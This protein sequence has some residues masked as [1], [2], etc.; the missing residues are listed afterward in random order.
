MANPVFLDRSEAHRRIVELGR[1]FGFEIDPDAKVGSLSVGWQ[2]RVEI[3][4]ALYRNARILVLDEPTAVLTPQETEEI[5]AVLRRLAAEG[6]RIVFISHKLYEVLEIADRITVIRRGRVVGQRDPRRDER[7]GPRRADGRPRGPADGR[8]RRV[9]PGRAGPARRGPPRRRTTAATRWS[10][11]STSR[12]GP[13][14]SSASP[15]SPATARTSSSRRSSGCA[16]RRR[17]RVTLA[18]TDVTGHSPRAMNEAGVALRARGPSPVRPD[19]V[20]LARRQPG[21]HELLPGALRARDP[22]R[23]RARSSATPTRASRAVRHPDAVGDRHG[24]RRCPAATSRRWSSP[25]SSTATSSCSSSTSRRAA[26]TSAASSSSIARSSPSATPGR[27]SCSSRRSSTRS[28]RCPTGSASCTRGQIVAVARR[29]DR[30]QERGGPADGDRR[31][32][33]G[34][35]QPRSRSR[36]MTATRAP[37]RRLPTPSRA[38]RRVD[39]AAD[40][41]A[42]PCPSSSILGALLA[43]RD[44]DP[45]LRAARPGQGVR[46]GL[47]LDGLLGPDPGRVRQLRRR[48]SPRSSTRRRSSSAASPSAFGF[49][50]GLFNIGAQGQFLIGALGLGHRRRRGGRPGR[51]CARHPARRPRR[52]RRRRGSGASSR[53]SSRRSRAPTRSSARSC[54]TTSPSQILAALVSGPLKVPRS[55]SP[56]TFDVGNAALPDHPR[57]ERPPRASCIALARRGLRL[58][59]AVPDDVGLRGP[60]RRREPGRG[61]LRRHAAAAASSSPT[62]TFSGALAGLAGHVRPARRH[63][64]D[65]LELRDDGRLRLDRG[66]PARALEPDRRSLRPRSSSAAM[67]A[68]AGLMQIQAQIPA[69]LVDV[70]QATILLFLVASPVLRRVLRAVHRRGPPGSR[71]PATR[72]LTARRCV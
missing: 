2:Q 63:P 52:H 8:P 43:R 30:R 29:P 49:K 36:P 57:A 41:D 42:S 48:S 17:A 47:P 68:G 25:A 10:G 56:I 11:A 4:K 58:V 59:A 19:P 44:R 32:R 13:A 62:M 5:F 38:G 28:W 15:A 64:L 53:A 21:P 72:P 65:D 33:P 14:R 51:R 26:S 6:H 46:P 50:A 18:G 31:H 70:L 12:S 9:A 71:R 16:S 24:R 27:R 69:E 34:R 35:R 54:S 7:G 37:A 23:R 55:P 60:G 39:A 45:R 3:L 67:R 66:R 22:A 20:V 61:P 1:R 40:L